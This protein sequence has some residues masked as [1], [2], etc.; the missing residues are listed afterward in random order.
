MTSVIFQD[1]NTMISAGAVDGNIKVWDLRKNYSTIRT[2]PLPYHVFPYSGSGTRKHG[3]NTELLVVFNQF[4]VH[5]LQ[6]LSNVFQHS[7][8]N[9]SQIYLE[10]RISDPSN[11]FKTIFIHLQGIHP[12]HWTRPNQNY[13]RTVQTTL[14]ICTTVSRIK[15]NHWRHFEVTAMRHSTS[16]HVSVL[17]TST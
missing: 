4:E 7:K 8:P 14:S 5:F 12:Y 1:V 2:E 13:S 17:M 3:K 6:D 9:I 16:S 10:P 11:V 15:S